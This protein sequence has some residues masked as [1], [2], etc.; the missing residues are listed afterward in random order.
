MILKGTFGGKN[1]SLIVICGFQLRANHNSGLPLKSLVY[2]I[3]PLNQLK[4]MLLSG[5]L[6]SIR[7]LRV[8]K[9]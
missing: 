4:F 9:D 1:P 5:F 3:F 7:G 8:A 6:V 2:R